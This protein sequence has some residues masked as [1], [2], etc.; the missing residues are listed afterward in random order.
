MTRLDALNIVTECR[1]SF[2]AGTITG[3]ELK[4]CII[5]YADLAGTTYDN[6]IQMDLIRMGG[7]T[8]I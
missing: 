2:E 4:A 5:Y 1:H 8:L 7:E 6:L 3:A